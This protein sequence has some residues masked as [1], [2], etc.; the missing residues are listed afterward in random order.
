MPNNVKHF[1]INA[2]DV[3]R[4]RSFYEN[5]FGWKFQSWGPPGFF[6][7]QTGDDSDPGIDGSLQGRRQIVEGKPI[8][9]F[10][11][12]MSV[13]SVDA[14]ASAVEKHGGKIVMPKVVIPTVGTLIFFEDTEGN[15]AGAM[16][17]DKNAE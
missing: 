13:T 2:D 6:L 7:I 5:V 17:Y 9:G 3:S 12:T 15:I 4:A 16:E 10:E 8:L 1:S 14:T 11:C